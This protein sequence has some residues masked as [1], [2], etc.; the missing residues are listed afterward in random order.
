M[1][2]NAIRLLELRPPR[3]QLAAWET[4]KPLGAV[5]PYEATWS[6]PEGVLELLCG[7]L[8]A[9]WIQLESLQL[10]L[11]ATGSSRGVHWACFNPTGVTPIE[12][13]VHLEAS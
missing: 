9:S 7:V 5:L 13:W 10:N 12:S 11:A 8:G 2:K 3:L 6:L 4:R 1:A